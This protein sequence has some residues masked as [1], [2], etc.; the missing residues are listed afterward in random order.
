[1]NNNWFK[2]VDWS[3]VARKEI[4][5]PWVPELTSKTDYSHFDEYPDSGE[6]VI[7][8]S[9]SEQKLFEEF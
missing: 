6:P 3:V 9:S 1:M 2:G 7:K 4:P 5:P 8:I